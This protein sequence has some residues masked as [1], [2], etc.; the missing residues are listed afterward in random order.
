MRKARKEAFKSS[1]AILKLQE[2]LKSMRA[3]M[4]VAQQNLDME[5][6]KIQHREQETFDAQ[7]QLVAVQEELE[8]MKAQYRVVEEE[9]DALKKS[10]KEE[11]VA[12]IAA[13][14]MIALPQPS[15]DDDDLLSSPSKR[16]PSKRPASPLSDDKE[17][18]GIV[19]KK[20]VEA[21]R[22]QDELK[23]ERMRREQAEEMADFLQMECQFQCCGCRT[24]GVHELRNIT[25]HFTQ[26]MDQIQKDMRK[27]L[28][29]P[30]FDEESYTRSDSAMLA[31]TEDEDIEMDH[32]PHIE[33]EERPLDR[34]MT[35]TEDVP[36]EHHTEDAPEM[37]DDCAI[38]DDFPEVEVPRAPHP[39]P[40]EPEPEFEEEDEMIRTASVKVPLLP[41]SPPGP[42]QPLPSTPF[43]QQASVRTITTTTTIPMQFTP[44]K[45]SHPHQEEDENVAPTANPISPRDRSGSAPTFDREAALAAIAYRRGRAKSIAMGHATPRKQMIEGV[46]KE[47][48]DISAPA[49]GQKKT[50]AASYMKGPASVGRPGR[51]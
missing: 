45:P 15:Q 31:R 6:R 1:S 12:R 43:R 27:V 19:T 16:S 17:N 40:M 38:E 51:R 4:R 30:K 46:S 44:A 8:Q 24:N 2:D 29:P 20:M 32:A 41:S 22:L 14:G 11:E 21:R 39:T 9:K 28:S 10:L 49:L 42:A 25:A 37:V 13:E 26:A 3:S 33:V 35:M 5:K 48:R 23:W 50:E 34:S 36:E 18:N 47:R 7:Y